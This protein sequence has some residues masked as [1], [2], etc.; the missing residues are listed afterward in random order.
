MKIKHFNCIYL[1]SVWLCTHD[2]NEDI[3]GPLVVVSPLLL[4]ARSPE[5]AP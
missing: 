2:V 4:E 3:R 1:F 5:S